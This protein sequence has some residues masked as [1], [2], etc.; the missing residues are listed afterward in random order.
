MTQPWEQQAEQEE[1][2][3]L[4]DFGSFWSVQLHSPRP[5]WESCKAPTFC[6]NSQFCSHLSTALLPRNRMTVGTAT[7]SCFRLTWQG[8]Q[9]QVHKRRHKCNDG[10]TSANF[11]ASS[12]K[13]SSLPRSPASFSNSCTRQYFHRS[14]YYRGVYS[15]PEK[16]TPLPTGEQETCNTALTVSHSGAQGAWKWTATRFEELM[17]DLYSVSFETSFSAIFFQV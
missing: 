9:C 13:H 16:Y 6:T 4:H 7:I 15:Y 1:E 10:N 2:Q 11:S 14:V 17:A 5:P 3:Q 12:W 8:C